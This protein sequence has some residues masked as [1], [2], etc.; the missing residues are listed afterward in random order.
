M[1]KL[2]VLLSVL[3]ALVACNSPQ[4]TTEEKARAIHSKILTVDSHTDTPLRFLRE[5]FDL[6]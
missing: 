5:D 1:R 3:T 2:I 4:Q 6:C